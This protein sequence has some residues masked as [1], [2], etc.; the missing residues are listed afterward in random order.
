MMRAN[1]SDLGGVLLMASV[2]AGVTDKRDELTAEAQVPVNASYSL[3]CG[4]A[5][6]A[7]S[8]LYIYRKCDNPS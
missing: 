7:Y 1:V 6:H 4:A 2:V 8:A 5:L 3:V